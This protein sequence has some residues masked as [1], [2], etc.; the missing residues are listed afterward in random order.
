MNES[1]LHPD[2]KKILAL[3]DGELSPGE[4]EEVR[5]H[6]ASCEECRRTRD[7]LASVGRVLQAHPD[8]ESLRPIWPVVQERLESTDRPLLRPLFGLAAS[9]AVAAGILLGV[10]LAPTESQPDKIGGAYLWSAVGSS[11]GETGG[12]TLSSAYAVTPSEEGR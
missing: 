12:E 11:L 7:D 1:G 5:G 2:G 10:L 3:L 6:C 9:A 8:E 4:A